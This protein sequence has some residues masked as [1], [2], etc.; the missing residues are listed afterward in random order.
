MQPLV[1]G[2]RAH[3]TAAQVVEALSWSTSTQL[4]WGV[5]VLSQTTLQPTGLTLD[6]V[7]GSVSWQYRAQP[8]DSTSPVQ[9]QVRRRATLTYRHVAGF[10]PLGVLYRLWVEMRAGGGTPS[11][12]PAAPS[13]SWGDP[14]TSWGDT[15]AWGGAA[16]GDPEW[17][18]FNVG[19]FAATMPPFAYDGF[20]DRQGP[21]VWRPLELADRSHF[22]QSDETSDPVIVEV[23][24]DIGQWV[25][26]DLQVR[27][28][29]PDVAG[30]AAVGVSA[31]TDYVFDGGTTWLE[32]YNTVLAAAGHEPLHADS[33]GYP[34]SRPLA[35]P[36]TAEPEHNYTAGSTVIPAATVEAANPDLPN[37]VRFVARRGPSLAEE[38]NG[39]RT[40]VNEVTGPGSL[41]QRGGRL[42]L[43]RVEVD[44]QTQNDLD[45]QAAYLAPFYFAGGG[46]RYLGDVGLNPRHDDGDVVRLDKSA[47]GIA[48]TWLVTNWE[49]RLGRAEDMAQMRLELEQLTGSAFIAV[50][51]PPVGA[52]GTYPFGGYP[53][54]GGT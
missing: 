40:I 39:I 11:T 53:F 30:V 27:F 25:R 37:A 19:V 4:R 9:A 32:I 12:G 51:P 23:G 20:T 50:A 52:F 44:A 41:Q 17:C 26:D 43:M 2:P 48:G 14:V 16:A 38:G 5:D 31:T 35:D 49:I 6:A 28:N 54:G 47:F 3:L 1:A 24:T 10:N 15:A 21:V 22:W 29:E 42:V 13:T 7:D 46:L 36:E 34:R 18:R 33:D 8:T 45:A